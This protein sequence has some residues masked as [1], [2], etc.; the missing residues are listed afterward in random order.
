MNAVQTWYEVPLVPNMAFDAVKQVGVLISGTFADRLP[1]WTE[2]AGGKYGKCRL[3]GIRND[4]TDRKIMRKWRLSM[5]VDQK[6][7][8][9]TIESFGAS[10]AWWAQYVGGVAWKQQEIRLS[11]RSVTTVILNG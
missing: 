9:Q 2:K 1:D 4:Y 11:E 3:C 6:R 10:R 7:T 5:R 8:Y